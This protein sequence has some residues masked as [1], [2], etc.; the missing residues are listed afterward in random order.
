MAPEALAPGSPADWLRHARS[1]LALARQRPKRGVLFDTLCYHAQQAVE[2]SLK[3][4]LLARGVPFPYTHD[5]ARLITLVRT[6]RADWPAELDAAASL[7]EY[8][9]SSRYPSISG[10]VTAK[11]RREAVRLAR[12]VMSWAQGQV[13]AASRR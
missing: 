11:Q 4:V 10:D 9:V 8:A 13:R 1:D 2:K 3:A 7:T 12:A 6:A 5:L